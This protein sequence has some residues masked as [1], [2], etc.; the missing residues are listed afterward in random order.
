MESSTTK[1]SLLQLIRLLT[2]I[3]L[4]VA[5]GLRLAAAPQRV[6]KVGVFPHAPA[7]FMGEDGQ[8]K[9]FY[10]DM[11]KEIAA[12]ED[13][14]LR[15]VPGTWQEGLDRVRSGE[16]DV[17]TSVALTPERAVFLDYGK[18]PSFTVWSILYADPDADIH[19][20]LD[21][22]NR[23]V[24]LMRGDM[25][26]MH[27]RELCDKFNIEVTF[28]EVGSFVDV[29]RAVEAKQADAG[30]ATNIFGYAQESK[31]RVER[32]P[33]VFS[34]FDTFFASAK[35]RNA[36]VLKALDTYLQAGKRNPESGYHQAINRW[37]DSQV[38]AGLP[39]WVLPT[40]VGTL[41]ALVLAI[42]LALAFRRQVDRATAKI[43]ELN[44][45][46]QRELAEKQRL[47]AQIL[48]VASGVSTSF[49]ES[50]FQNLVKHLA[51]ATGADAAF[52]GEA[53]D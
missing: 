53:I 24:A 9:G 35:H 47:E 48:H 41:A 31:F 2:A 17:I 11:L 4:V 3:F 45:G 52:I 14:D 18:E 23:R 25:N 10:A 28:Q 15:F 16:V 51:Q 26:G 32:T 12:K 1:A 40:A 36:D 49:G 33:V 38:K 8:A 21:V 19:T 22:K 13:W 43:Q 42:L 34:P 50:F 39:P 20:I 27:F 29:M 46:L 37:L 44:V 6:V 7:L 30:V 5:G